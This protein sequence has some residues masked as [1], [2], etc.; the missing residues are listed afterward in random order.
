MLGA[1]EESFV[2][3]ERRGEATQKDGQ[4]KS[5][6]VVEHYGSSVE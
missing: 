3:R 6:S 4:V 5:G 2:S 1:R